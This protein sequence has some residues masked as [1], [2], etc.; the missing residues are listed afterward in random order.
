MA[1]MLIFRNWTLHDAVLFFLV[2][3][4]F[5]NDN[6]SSDRNAKAFLVRGGDAVKRGD[7][8]DPPNRA[9]SGVIVMLLHHAVFLTVRF[10]N[11]TVIDTQRS[12]LL[13]DLPDQ[14]LCQF[15][16]RTGK[17]LFLTQKTSDLIVTDF[18]QQQLG[19]HGGTRLTERGDQEIAVQF[20]H[21][22]S[23]LPSLRRRSAKQEILM[24]SWSLQIVARKVRM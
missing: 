12:V 11:H 13:L 18:P 17:S 22:A 4:G 14:R 6:F 1:V 20:H 16:E 19:E 21:P 9:P 3:D 10:G 23:H 7:E 2:P 5:F 8:A 24:I 15:P